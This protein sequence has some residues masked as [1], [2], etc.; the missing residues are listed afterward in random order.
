MAELDYE[1]IVSQLQAEN[2]RLRLRLY[3]AAAMH[4]VSLDMDAVRSWLI[5]NYIV[6]AACALLV[7]VAL[8]VVETVAKHG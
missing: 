6:I 7:S 1:A 3:D 8:S 5:E 2:E 4:G